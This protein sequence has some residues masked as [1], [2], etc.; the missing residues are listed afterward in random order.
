[1]IAAYARSRRQLC[2]EASRH[3]RYHL[4][5]GDSPDK[6]EEGHSKEGDDLDVLLVKSVEADGQNQVAAGQLQ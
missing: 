5:K 2:T 4:V 3:V 1:M 6:K